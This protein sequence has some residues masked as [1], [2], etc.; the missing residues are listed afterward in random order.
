VIAPWAIVDDDARGLLLNRLG[1]AHPSGDTVIQRVALVEGT[2]SEAVLRWIIAHGAQPEAAV[3]TPVRRGVREAPASGRRIPWGLENLHAPRRSQ[4]IVLPCKACTARALRARHSGSTRR[5][6]SRVRCWAEG[7]QDVPTS[8]SAGVRC[9]VRPLSERAFRQSD[10]TEGAWATCELWRGCANVVLAGIGR[11][12]R[13]ASSSAGAPGDG[14][15]CAWA[16]SV[17]ISR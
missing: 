16:G 15:R 10:R 11:A 12:P 9:V 5:T 2:G 1:R 6:R 8:P 17:G 4:R 7:S 13:S 3:I 14:L